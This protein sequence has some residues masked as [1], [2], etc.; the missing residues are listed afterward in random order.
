MPVF[1]RIVVPL[2]G[3]RFAEHAVPAALALVALGHRPLLLAHV[4]V[5]PLPLDQPRA[6]TVDDATP[7]DRYEALIVDYLRDVARRVSMSGHIEAEWM[8]LTGD[9]RQAVERLAVDSGAD[10]VAMASHDSTTLGSLLA[11]S[12]GEG[13][14]RDGGLPVLLLRKPEAQ[15]RLELDADP[16]AA[17]DPITGRRAE[18]RHLL[19]PL[20]G[21]SLAEAVLEPAKRFARAAGARITL[22]TVRNTSHLEGRSPDFATREYLEMVA[23]PL[24]TAGLV[25]DVAELQG[26]DVAKV[27]LRAITDLSAD[28]IGMATH[29]RGGLS[30]L[31]HGSVAGKVLRGV[32]MPVLLV[33]P[34][35]SRA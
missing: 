1:R 11:G 4:D 3:T 13:I 26:H 21:G 27:I 29:G 14:L 35:S 2:D 30:R 31:L 12:V 28:V 16:A 6:I 10:L 32:L 7:P 33:R 20:D 25:I 19:I 8:I 5:A 15:I 9:V 18:F 23:R 17:V 34:R 22:L 24:R